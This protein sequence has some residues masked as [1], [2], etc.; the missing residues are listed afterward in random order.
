MLAEWQTAARTDVVVVLARPAHWAMPLPSWCAPLAP[1]E[2]AQ[3]ARWRR[4][5][6]AQRS[7][8]GTFLARHLLAEWLGTT[9]PDV[10]L[11]RTERGKPVLGA[12]YERSGPWFN[13]AHSG[14]WVA[15]AFSRFGRVGVDVEVPHA[16]PDLPALAASAFLAS[17]CRQVLD[18]D[19]EE[20]H[21]RFFRLWTRKEAMLKATGVGIDGLADITC[22]VDASVGN[23]LLHVS[24]PNE[25]ADQWTVRSLG[26]AAASVSE[27]GPAGNRV[28]AALPPVAVAYEGLGRGVRAFLV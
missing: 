23:A 11:V 15:V 22:A 16:L 1:D 8:A 10:P 14:D 25:P 6:D 12:P 28:P 21:R 17:E 9:P 2:R 7:A 19:D 4:H 3:V 27:S 5:A 18:G 20:R 26:F 13:I 24:L